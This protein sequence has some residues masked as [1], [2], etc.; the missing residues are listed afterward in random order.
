MIAVVDQKGEAIHASIG[1]DADGN[2]PS[3]SDSFRVGSITKVF[4]PLATL[5]LVDE[6]AIDL[7]SPAADYVSRV[8]VP[9][10]V[11]VRD[12]LRHRSGIYNVTDVPGF[13]A[14][15]FETPQRVWTAEDQLE[16]I[17]DR[18]PLFEPGSQFRYSNSTYVILGVLIEE[19][20]GQRYDEVIRARIIDPLDLTATYLDGFEDGPIPFDPYDHDAASVGDAHYDYTSIATS[21]LR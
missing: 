3:A 11:T 8:A 6:G 20:T 9:A 14:T 16:L 2:T 4:T 18:D 21:T 19:V 1:S 10:N 15:V 7:D 13:F 12:L 17:D 5:T